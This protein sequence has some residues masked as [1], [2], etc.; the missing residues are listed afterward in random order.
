MAFFI[1][2]VCWA[3]SFPSYAMQT[4]ADI[5]DH[6]QRNVS[7]SRSQDPDEMMRRFKQAIPLAELQ[8]LQEKA[9]RA[10]EEIELRKQQRIDEAVKR[11]LAY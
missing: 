7:I 5:S 11:V 1:M 10:L 4:E 6:Q 2:L 9:R 8:R 3:F